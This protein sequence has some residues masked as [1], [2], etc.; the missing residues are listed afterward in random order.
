MGRETSPPQL[1]EVSVTSRG[2]EK[3]RKPLDVSGEKNGK[4]GWTYTSLK[5]QGVVSWP[6]TETLTGNLRKV[7]ERRKKGEDEN[8]TVFLII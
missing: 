7:K 3:R 4:I 1:G 8:K 6:G 5:A 2:G